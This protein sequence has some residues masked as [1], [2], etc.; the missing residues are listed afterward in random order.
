MRRLLKEVFGP[1]VIFGL[2][3]CFLTFPMSLHPGSFILGR[4]FEDAFEAIWYLYWYQHAIIDLHQSPLVQPGIFY[5]IGWDLRLAALPPFYPSVLAPITTMLGPVVTYNLAII[6]SAVIAAYGVFRVVKTMGGSVGGGV[7]A[8]IAFAFCSNREV[9]FE[10]FLNHLL[11]S[12]W[13]PWILYGALRTVQTPAHR[14]RWAVFTF[15]AYALAIAGAWQAAL[16]G[17]VII[18][19]ALLA[20]WVPAYKHQLRIP[21]QLVLLGSIVLL[22]IAGPLVWGAVS[23]QRELGSSAHFSFDNIDGTSVSVE[24]LF[25]PSWVNPLLR[26]LDQKLFPPA[27]G[28]DGTVSLGYTAAILALL[29]WWRRKPITGYH[30]LLL[31]L[32]VIAF[33][34]MLGPTLHFWG[35][36]V[37]LS[38]PDFVA[39]FA[40]NLSQEYGIPLWTDAGLRVPLPALLAY[41]F[42]PPLRFF[43][44]FGRW[45]LVAALALATMAGM[46]LSQL[47]TKLKPGARVIS[48][49]IVCLLVLME[50]NTQ[51]ISRITSTTQ[52]HRAVDDWLAANASDSVIIEYPL[53]Y[54][55]KGQSLYY[56]M[57]HRQKI[58]HG[59]SQLLPKGYTDLLP[60]LNQWPGPNALDLLSEVGVK[61]ILVHA[62]QGDDFEQKTLPMLLDIPRLKLIQMFPTPIG[63]VRQ[64]Y[65][66]ELLS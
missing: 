12:M 56:T 32:L 61:Y 55:M 66:F 34:L 25:A 26:D 29:W 48:V 13:Y 7:F 14:A 64:I 23:A 49:T 58:V 11:A 21:L 4:P 33:V 31:A 52:M 43:H 47:G 1:L 39:R 9:Y 38:V 45:S 63:P 36:P 62:F 30:K 2:V 35:K 44:H 60:V 53:S 54:T 40:G 42:V 20:Y 6:A 41:M 18:L 28:E 8:G 16:F 46:G 50:I 65:L 51:P 17:G 10:G 27:N 24:R 57:A 22:L 5:P 15:I 3:T 19:V 59:Y 37:L